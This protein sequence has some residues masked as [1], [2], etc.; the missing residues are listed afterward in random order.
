MTKHPY[1]TRTLMHA[2][3][4]AVTLTAAFV[5][6]L[7]SINLASASSPSIFDVQPELDHGLLGE[8]RQAY[9]ERADTAR[10]RDA[11]RLFKEYYEQNPDDPVAAWH[12]AM[13][14]Y[15]MG[16]RVLSDGEAKKQVHDEG[17]LAADRGVAQDPECAPCH[18]LSGINHALWAREVGIFRSLVGLPKVRNHLNLS[19][20]LDPTFAGAAAYRALAQISR[21]LPRMFGGGKKKTIGHLQ[22]A[23]RAAPNEPLNYEIMVDL[24]IKDKDQPAALYW[25]QRGVAVPEPGP[26]W[27][28]SRDSIDYMQRIID[29][30]TKPLQAARRD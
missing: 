12:F 10:G 30:L 26:A 18:L 2:H 5:L 28:E 23:F 27:V 21:A 6:V 14:C 16:H 13:S 3:R 11:Y 8:G 22:N 25:A 1:P 7:G 9:R 24:M 19:A 15:F 17:R 4:T 20:E 29:A